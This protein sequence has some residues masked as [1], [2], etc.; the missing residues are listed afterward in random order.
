MKDIHLAPIQGV[1]DYIFRNTF[2]KHFSGIDLYYTPFLRIQNGE[3]RRHDLKDID[4]QNDKTN[5]KT[6]PQIMA[7]NHEEFEL[8]TNVLT[9]FGYKRIDINMGC[10]FP[11]ITKKH[12][13]SGILMYPSEVKE[14]IDLVNN[15]T[16][17]KFSLKMR[18]GQENPNECMELVDCFN[19]SRLTQIVV[20]ARLGKQQ[21]NG[22]VDH[23]AFD[24][25]H[26]ASTIPT[27][28]NGDIKT[29]NDINDVE[30]KWPQSPAIMI[31]R[32]LL[33]N[34]LLAEEYKNG[35]SYSKK[36]K[37]KRIKEFM[38]ELICN[39][40]EVFTGGDKQTI[41]RINFIWEL[42]LPDM[43]KR[44]RKKII[45]SSKLVDYKSNIANA[46]TSYSNEE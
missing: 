38:H 11:V 31:G 21:Y 39:Y 42:L 27:I 6:I 34:P 24:K 43:E 13:G 14:I 16:D 15:K 26:N 35:K 22:E 41:N 23:I 44:M 3:I 30:N 29:V 5:G 33:S 40:E 32:G 45:K 9:D 8:L 37:A 2:E 10:P 1:T 7:N 17:V 36:E 46:L 25:F 18:L 12:K 28:Y 20:H 19:N 4:P